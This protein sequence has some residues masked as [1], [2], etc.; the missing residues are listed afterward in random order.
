MKKSRQVKQVGE[1]TILKGERPKEIRD[2]FIGEVLADKG[3]TWS[4][5]KKICREFVH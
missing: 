2:R 3:I 4:E 1:E 5:A